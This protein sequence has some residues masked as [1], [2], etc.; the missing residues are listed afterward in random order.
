MLELANVFMRPTISII[1]SL[2][3][4]N[5]V[6][7]RLARHVANGL[8]LN[9]MV[10]GTD[11]RFDRL[12]V[13]LR[14]G[15]FSRVV[16][17]MTGD[18]VFVWV[19]SRKLYFLWMI[20]VTSEDGGLLLIARKERRWL[21]FL[22]QRLS[23]VPSRLYQWS[24]RLDRLLVLPYI[25]HFFGG[26]I[27]TCIATCKAN[28]LSLWRTPFLT[29]NQ[30]L[31]W[32]R[33]LGLCHAHIWKLLNEFLLFLNALRLWLHVSVSGALDV[34]SVAF[35]YC[36]DTVELILGQLSVEL[37][38]WISLRMVNCFWNM[39]YFLNKLLRYFSPAWL[40]LL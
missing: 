36:L 4:Q 24:L 35:S 8:L 10:G 7:L 13:W 28:C 23:Q 15:C 30:I 21:H 39:L 16:Y 17:L 5:S 26:D 3:L 9:L 1:L 37:L 34:Y 31:R 20:S 33:N 29:T 27:V 22:I 14:H 38:I 32:H 19:Q 11:S 40:G 12:G 2:S 18:W 6:I 25:H